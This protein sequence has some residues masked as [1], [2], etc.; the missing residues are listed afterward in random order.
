[1]RRR[2]LRQLLPTTAFALAALLGSAQSNVA[3]AALADDAAATPAACIA[4]EGPESRSRNNA[5]DS[6]EIRYTDGT[7]YDDA[8]N[9]GMATWNAVG[10]IKYRPD[11]VTTSNDLKII[12]ANLGTS[13]D[14]PLGNY[15]W[16]GGW[17]ATDTLRMNRQKL[18]A[19]PYTQRDWRRYVFLHEGGHSLGL[20][21]KSDR[22]ASLMWRR[23]PTQITWVPDVDKANYKRLWG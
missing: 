13:A 16:D 5:V 22:V 15:T 20:C 1:M 14:A 17:A 21:H 8:R 9:H 7:V 12:D 6:G 11:T 4:G 23:S 10:P 3:Y 19:W 2:F 18:N